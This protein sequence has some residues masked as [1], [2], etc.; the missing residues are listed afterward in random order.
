VEPSE[1]GRQSKEANATFGYHATGSDQ[2]FR[3]PAPDS[4]H[5]IFFVTYD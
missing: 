3:S 1:H 5:S 2:K 4:Q